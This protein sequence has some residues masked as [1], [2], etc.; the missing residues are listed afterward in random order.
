[1]ESKDCRVFEPVVVEVIE[2]E[3]TD[4]I[5]RSHSDVVTPEVPINNA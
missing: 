3:G 5:V 4:I 2:F 1:M